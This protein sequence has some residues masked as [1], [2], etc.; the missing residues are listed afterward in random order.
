MEKLAPFYMAS[1]QER[2]NKL[3]RI[4]ADYVVTQLEALTMIY[5]YCLLDNGSQ[6]SAGYG[7]VS[8]VSD[9]KPD[10]NQQNAEIFRYKN[11]Q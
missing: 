1:N 3:G 8:K 6:I 9:A 7:S 4:P 10:V 2:E 5:H 11:D